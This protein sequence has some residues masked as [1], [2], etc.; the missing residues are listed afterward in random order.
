M[1]IFRFFTSRSTIISLIFLALSAMLL[2]SVIPQA[3]LLTTA[4]LAK[5]YAEYPR[6]AALAEKLGLTHVYTH[7][8]F[9]LIL[10]GVVISLGCSC[11]E[12][13]RRA[14]QFWNAKTGSESGMRILVDSSPAEVG[15]ILRRHSYRKN[16][17]RFVRHALGY[18]GS[19]LMHVGMLVVVAASLWI[20]LFQKRGII[21][22]SE[23]ELSKPGEAWLSTERGLLA[24]QFV[25][26][27]TV[28]LD[29]VEYDYWPSYAVKRVASNLAFI[30]REGTVTEKL[31]EINSIVQ[32]R[33]IRVY[34]GIDFGHSF[35][36]EISTPDGTVTGLQLQIDHQLTPD[37]AG[38]ADFE[39]FFGTRKTL[40]VKYF[41]E[42]DQ[43]SLQGKNPLLTMRLDEGGR[44]IGRV[45]LTSGATGALAEYRVRLL[46][47]RRWSSFIF[48]GLT[49]IS[50]VF[51]GFGI[52]SLG[53]A[54]HYFTTPREAWVREAQGGGT[55]ISWRATKFAGFYLDEFEELRREIIGKDQHE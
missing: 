38:Y 27:D 32:H 50:A 46:E 36:V 8:L 17:E 54:L 37:K 42:A 15:V 53:G 2:G 3:F 7:P 5:W 33:G 39:N 6:L 28:R 9:A 11:Y 43:S 25:L 19:T 21:R 51:L 47:V 35:F 16:G 20:A 31:T 13:T 23:G 49:G 24:G 4:G 22:I 52:I 34:Q 26:D 14:L 10:S 48:V 45:S 41:A 40:R 12:Q 30:S 18:W 29:R 1:N 44:E 55:E